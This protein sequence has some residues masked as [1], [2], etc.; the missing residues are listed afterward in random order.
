MKTATK[1]LII[2]AVTLVLIGFVIVCIALSLGTSFVSNIKEVTYTKDGS[3]DK[4]SIA[5]TEEDI[6]IKKSTD[7][8]F[9]AVCKEADKISYS[10]NIQNGELQL[11]RKDNRAWFDFIEISTGR[12]DLTLYLPEGEY[13]QLSAKTESGEIKCH[14]KA[15]TFGKVELASASGDISFSANATGELSATTTSGDIKLFGISP[16]SISLK[17]SSGEIELADISVSEDISVTVLSGEVE[18]EDVR[19]S[20]TLDIKSTSGDISLERCDAA[21]LTLKSTSGSIYGTLLSDKL[22]EASST[23]G[24]IHCPPS[25]KDGGKCTVSTTSGGIRLA[26]IK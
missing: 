6:S 4:I 13:T 21:E 26:I 19:S 12:R 5:L 22:F 3:F 1:I 18:L 20:K 15:I 17:S 16:A 25:V 11:V 2:I 10:V 8:N 7:G 9:Y 24:K 14:D 23:S